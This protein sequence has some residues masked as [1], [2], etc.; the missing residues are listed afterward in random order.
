MQHQFIIY[1]IKYYMLTSGASGIRKEYHVMHIQYC[2]YTPRY[3]HNGFYQH[4]YGQ[5][6]RSSVGSV[7]N[8]NNN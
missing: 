2:T 1:N 8:L 4:T 6:P 5:V 3:P 7:V